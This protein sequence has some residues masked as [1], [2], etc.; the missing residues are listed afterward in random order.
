[1]YNSGSETRVSETPH[2]LDSS[3]S[4]WQTCLAN[5]VTPAR[6]L[7]CLGAMMK[8]ISLT[9]GFVALVDDEDYEGL[10]QH[11]WCVLRTKGGPYAV[12][13]R[14]NSEKGSRDMVYMHRQL[15]G[16]ESGEPVDHVDHSGLNNQRLNIRLCT[17]SQNMGNQR[18]THGSS[19]FKG[20]YWHK[21][22]RKWSADITVDYAKRHL[23]CFD[24]EHKAAHA[25]NA[26][27]FEAFGEFALLNEIP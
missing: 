7:S 26:A 4:A 19:R 12:R 5:Y 6:A 1:M 23:G 15:L 11:K 20:V 9:Q 2:S 13:R 25:Y 3:P 14:R 17:Q 22:N 10:M 21:Q 18:K 8:Q 24:D 27:A 16:A